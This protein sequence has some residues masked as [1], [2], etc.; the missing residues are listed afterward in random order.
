MLV[1]ACGLALIASPSRAD[2]T[3]QRELLLFD[4]PTVSAATKHPEPAREAPAAVTVI[5]H[6]DIHRFGYRT[7][8][9]VLRSVSGFY[10]SYDRNYDYVGVRGFLRPG[11][12]NDRILVLVNGHTYN[13]DIFQTALL[14]HEF[15]IDLEAIDHVEVI[16]GPGSALYGGNAL[17]AVVN[18]V[19]RTGAEVNGVESHLDYGSFGAK[20]GQILGGTRLGEAEVFASGSFFDADGQSDLRFPQGVAHDLDGQRAY[21]AFLSSRYRGWGFQGGTNGREKQIPTGAY[22]TTFDVA[23]TQTFD[24][25]SFADL[26]YTATPLEPL[27]VAMRAFYDGYH[28]HG[29]YIYGRGRSQTKNEDLADSDWVGGEVRARWQLFE[30]DALTLGT[31]YSYHP[32]ARQQNFDRPTGTTYLD[33]SRSFGTWGVYAQNEWALTKRLR[34]VTGLRYDAYYDGRITQLSPRGALIWDA[35]EDTTVKLL[36]GN[37]FRPPNLLEQYYAYPGVGVQQ[38]ANPNLAAERNTTY[39]AVLEQGLWYGIRGDIALYR[40]DI[41]NLIEQVTLPPTG[42][43]TTRTQYRNL[44]SVEA[45]GAEFEVRV[46]LPRGGQLRAQ[47][48][49][50]EAT[51]D[52]AVLSNSPRNLGGVSL[53]YPLPLGVQAA[54]Q[55]LVVGPRRT[56]TGQRLEAAPILSF[57]LNVPTPIPHVGVSVSLYNLFDHMYPDPVGAEIQGNRVAQDGRTFRVQIA[58]VF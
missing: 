11:D 7:L 26:T 55:L 52:G 30:S 31:E 3:P 53:L 32:Q 35:F 5:T 56:S 17:F 6:E 12:Y 40:Y 58:Y 39:E 20:H 21:N 25:R 24:A 1:A 4:E 38:V 45:D 54:S 51:S 15:G 18:V 16:R 47:Y 19:T 43:G 27:T 22:G 41:A 50:Q 46:P 13:D 36:I 28:Y 33:D 49:Y 42:S 14:G 44:S 29:T 34:L 2:E 57:T 8:A 37:A 10:G 48:A 9:E 23:G